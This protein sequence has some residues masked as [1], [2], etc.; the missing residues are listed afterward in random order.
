M[1][2]KK[3]E[4]KPL[5]A[6]QKNRNSFARKRRLSGAK[7]AVEHVFFDSF[8]NKPEPEFEKKKKKA[9]PKKTFPTSPNVSVERVSSDEED[10]GQ[11]NEPDA[12]D[13][14]AEKIKNLNAGFDDVSSFDIFNKDGEQVDIIDGKLLVR[15]V[16][17]PASWRP[18]VREDLEGNYPKM[19]KPFKKKVISKKDNPQKLDPIEKVPT[20]PA[21]PLTFHKSLCNSLRAIPQGKRAIRNMQP[22]FCV[23]NTPARNKIA[24]HIRPEAEKDIRSSKVTQSEGSDNDRLSAFDYTPI[25]ESHQNNDGTFDRGLTDLV[26]S[27]KL[28]NASTPIEN[29]SK[30]QNR[31]TGGFP[32]FSECAFANVL[33]YGNDYLDISDHEL[34]EDCQ[35]VTKAAPN[36]IESI[37]E[38]ANLTEEQSTLKASMTERQKS[39]S[40]IP[41]NNPRSPFDSINEQPDE[42]SPC[43]LLEK[44]EESD[45][46]ESMNRKAE[47]SVTEL[48]DSGDGEDHPESNQNGSKYSKKRQRTKSPETM[49]QGMSTV[50][51]MQNGPD[52]ME[53]MEEAEK[54]NAVR[55]R[56]TLQPQQRQL[57]KE[58]RMSRLSVLSTASSYQESIN[59][60][61]EDM[62]LD[63]HLLDE[64]TMQFDLGKTQFSESRAES[65]NVPTAMTIHNEDPSMLPFYL[66]DGTFETEPSHMAQLLHVVGQK[67]TKT[68]DS[69]PKAAFDGRRVT[70]IGEG[71]YGEVFLTKWEGKPVAI[72]VVPFEADKYN[73][74]YT[75][76]YHSV[77]MQT[78]DQILPELIV[79]KE[80]NQ[81]KNVDSDNST[82]N[83]IELIAAEIV[84]GNYPKGLLKAWDSYYKESENTR[85]D[86]YSSKNQNF[87]VLV[88]ANGGVA[89][90]DFVLEKEKEIFSILIQLALSILAAELLMEFEHRDLH[91]GNLLIDR[92]GADKLDYKVNGHKIPLEVHGVK[93]NII[94]FTLSR[95]SKEGTTVYLDL[96]QDPTIFEGENDPQFD[97]YRE[98]RKSNRGDW[99]VFNAKSNLMWIEYIG[100]RL[101]EPEICP[102]GLLTEE[103][104]KELRQLISMLGSYNTVQESL[105]DTEFYNQFYE[106]YLGHEKA[107]E[108]DI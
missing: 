3:K 22:S 17:P 91:I 10:A 103:R 72:K 46:G 54:E 43:E 12:D 9:P 15:A 33:I 97:V 79:M 83:F 77:Q 64:D 63:Q 56:G 75:G 86:V 96:E 32:V 74:L 27:P 40:G 39:E 52:E 55:K 81:L 101:L 57:D 104:K 21:E 34:D 58:S 48:L 88:S 100:K 107:P 25:C 76:E 37:N 105:I 70:K 38:E 13:D 60:A 78:A 16:Q 2:P 59:S 35:E 7:V 66:K 71:S 42:V 45:E 73:R 14:E 30:V 69:L 62:S 23:F 11:F 19:N 24:M 51:T 36:S 8:R 47:T 61:M 26:F 108:V 1:P 41:V 50:L 95:I 99:K 5:T 29:K 31:K 89:M 82:P 93:V 87:A 106:G 20:K 28:K 80:L 4:K 94:D 44:D 84:T 67:E 102:E 92:N 90:E 53:M 49:C 65:R 6:E 85:P 68:W 98:M 18:G